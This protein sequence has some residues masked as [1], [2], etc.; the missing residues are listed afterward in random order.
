VIN[1]GTKVKII[2]G[3]YTG[4]TGKVN[5]I[6]G[7]KCEIQLDDSR[8]VVVKKTDIEELPIESS[9]DYGFFETGYT[10]Q[11]SPPVSPPYAPSSVSPQYAPYSPAYVPSESPPYAQDSESP[12]WRPNMT[13]E[14]SSPAA[15]S[16]LEVPKEP[17]DKKEEDKKEDKEPSSS[18][19]SGDK[20]VIDISSESSSDVTT[21]SGIRKINI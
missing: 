4:K 18:S 3:P 1:V 12:I 5:R 20:K 6:V 15:P 17:E 13:P 21:S 8:K 10:P 14:Q 9:P 19:D 11:V 2:N 16:V 7:D